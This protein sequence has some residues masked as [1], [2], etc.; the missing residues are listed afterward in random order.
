MAEHHH[1]LAE[2]ERQRLVEA[3]ERRVGRNADVPIVEVVEAARGIAQLYLP[4]GVPRFG[5]AVRVHQISKRKVGR[6]VDV[7]KEL[8][9]RLNGYIVLHTVAP[10]FNQARFE[11]AVL[12]GRNTIGELA[13]IRH[14]DFLIPTLLPHLPLA[15]ERIKAIERKS[16]VG[17]RHCDGRIAHIL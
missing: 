7:F 1:F 10:I 13:R 11:Q 17:Q 15:A 3:V 4:H 5:N 9:G 14:R 16:Q 6:N 2:K 8:E 12:L